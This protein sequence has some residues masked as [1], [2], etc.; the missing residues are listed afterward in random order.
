VTRA[1]GRSLAIAAAFGTALALVAIAGAQPYGSGAGSSGSAAAGSATTGSAG[2]AA[3]GSGGGAGSGGHGSG[4]AIIIIIPPDTEPPEVTAAASPTDLKLGER[5][6]LYITATYGLGVEVNLREPIDLGGAFEVR[7]R[8]SNDSVRQDGRHVR[9]WQIDV[10]A[11]ELGD[12]Q[13]PPMAVTFTVAGKAGQVATNA[14]PVRVTGVLGDSDDPKLMRDYAPPV[15]LHEHNWLWRFLHWWLDNP[16]RLGILVGSLIA[17]WMTYRRLRKKQRRVTRLVGTLAPA[18]VVRRK[19]DMT[20][21]RALERLLAI[22]HSGVLDRDGDRKDA[23]NEMA[24]VIRDYIGARFGISTLE[25]TTAELLRALGGK[26]NERDH[27]MVERWLERCDLVKYG[28]F[29]ATATDAH[30]VLDDARALVVATTV[31]PAQPAEE[32]AA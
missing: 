11:W 5:F 1:R 16:M 20:S 26:A 3:A 15:E 14:V 23:Y 22:E 9:E 18:I 6:T 2:S 13:V 27:A 10:F 32:A 12:L 24:E 7:K 30:G 21:E 17:A 4:S 8:V 25:A 28:G 29:H 19:I 31:T